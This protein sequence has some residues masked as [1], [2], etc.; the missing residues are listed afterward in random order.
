MRY[1]AIS[2]ASLLLAM[3]AY[4]TEV[5]GTINTGLS[6]GVEGTVAATPTASPVA[7]TYDTELDVTLTASG[8]DGIRYTI[9]SA[10]PTCSTGT[11][12]SGAI[13]IDSSLT[14]RAVACYNDTAS[15][16]GIFAYGIDIT[17]PEDGGGGGGGGGGG[18]LPSS[19][20]ALANGDINSDG[21]VNIIDFNFVVVAWGSTGSNLSADFN[22]DGV[23]D[24]LDFNILVVNWTN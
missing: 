1:I 13:S 16:V 10:A 20:P 14:I 9:D 6:T 3:P 5:S 8:A 21:S 11:A 19:T 2:L 22:H 4:A 15:Q 7:G 24:V 18:P 17:P 12:Y 23:V